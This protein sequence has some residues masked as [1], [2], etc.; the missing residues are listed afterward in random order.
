MEWCEDPIPAPILLKLT[1]LTG[2]EVPS[3]HGPERRR[4]TIEFVNVNR[5]VACLTITSVPA[6]SFELFCLWTMRSALEHPASSEDLKPPDVYVPAA[7]TCIF[8]AGQQMYGWDKEFEQGPR[9]GAPGR[10]GPLWT[11]KHG[12]CTERW[13]LW[14]TRFKEVASMERLGD[15][16]KMVAKE[17][18]LRMEEIEAAATA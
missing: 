7:A 15:E 1:H 12:F 5:F 9:V 18:E 3:E 10:G 14:R 8:I 11:G 4:V 17:A 13:T 6:L 2:L 16:L